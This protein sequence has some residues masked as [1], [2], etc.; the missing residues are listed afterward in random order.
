MNVHEG[1]FIW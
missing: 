1:M